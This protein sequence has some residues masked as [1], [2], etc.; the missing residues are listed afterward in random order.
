MTKEKHHH[1]SLR[2]ALIRETR[3]LVSLHGV[4]GFTI[5]DACRAAG[6]ST[7]APYKHFGSREELIAEVS[8]LGF[9]ELTERMNAA[10]A[11]HP[12]NSIEA[13]IAMG[14]AYLGFV[15]ADPEMFHL[16]WGAT[17]QKFKNDTVEETGR[18]CFQRLVD[19]I[20]PVR[21]ALNLE[22][23]DTLEI[24]LALWS[25]IHGLAG[26]QLGEKLKVVEGLDLNLYVDRTT[27]AYF[28]GL[29]QRTR[30]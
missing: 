1:G 14:Q 15:S 22:T 18:A 25:G 30:R 4:E 21:T 19:A 5:A 26:L 9:E 8:A 11:Q 20:E 17:R 3:R 12:A 13:L 23:V 24:A 27:R 6:V 16:M 10:C 28:S 7:A 2:E 29:Q